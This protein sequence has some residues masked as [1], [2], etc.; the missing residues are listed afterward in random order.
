MFPATAATSDLIPT[1]RYNHP[2]SFQETLQDQQVGLARLYE[3]TAFSLRAGCEET[4]C[5][6]SKGKVS[7]SPGPVEFLHLCLTC[8]QRIMF[9]GPL[10]LMQ[11]S[12]DSQA[13]KPDVGIKTLTPV[14]EHMQCNCSPVS[15][16]PTCGV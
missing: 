7:V 3:F 1:V 6:P 9:W 12:L 5:A 10:L 14:G 2:P 11:D 15:Q 8:L 4:F 16:S 13:E